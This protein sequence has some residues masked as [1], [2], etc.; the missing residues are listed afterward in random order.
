VTADPLEFVRLDRADVYK[1]GD[2]VARFER[3]PDG[4]AFQYLAD[5]VGGPAVATTL[6]S[7]NDPVLMPGRAIPPYFAGLL[8]EG[9]RLT[10]LRSTL[11]T[12][13]D[14][15]FSM[16]LAVGGDPVGDVQVVPSGETPLRLDA[17][18][19]GAGTEASVAD[20]SFSRMFEEVVDGS[21][22]PAALAGVQDKISGR[23]INLP[24]S[25]GGTSYLLKLDPPEFPHLVAN[26]QF[27]IDMARDCGVPTVRS[28]VV[29]DVDGR[30]GLL[31]ERF[32]RATSDG[33]LVA[34][35]VEDG[36]QAAGRYPGDKYALDTEAVFGRLA[37]H[38]AAAPVARRDLLRQLIVAI[39][40][41][42]GDLHA[43]NV[44]MI[45]IADEWRIAPAYDVPSSAPYGDRSLAL[46]LDGSRDG[47]VSR[48]RLVRSGM[49][50][51]LPERAIRLTI[52]DLVDRLEPWI[53]RLDALP[54]DE[55]RIADTRR[56]MRSR[57]R[58]LRG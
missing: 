11:K 34:L 43:K 40:T 53:D 52:D 2:L 54:F 42:N 25:A 49:V 10:A 27:F 14:D 48:S 28:R 47:Q 41:G 9:R 5:H 6:P 57:V 18:I 33:H 1:A 22:D 23:M 26:E 13:A 46:A 21:I 45:R 15:D 4:I 24:I 50:M 31:V 8:P 37:A 35:A 17:P 38:C 32:D 51:G 7:T 36:C 39:V 20:V 29:R 30:P 19:D 56:L 58:L 55:R 3:R 16:L 12:S 44:S